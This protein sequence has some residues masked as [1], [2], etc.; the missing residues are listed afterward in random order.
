M[1]F[2]LYFEVFF[3]FVDNCCKSS[4]ALQ[5][6]CLLWA[7]TLPHICR[8]MLLLSL[9]IIFWVSSQ[10]MS[11]LGFFPVIQGS[12]RFFT[13]LIFWDIFPSREFPGFQNITFLCKIVIRTFATLFKNCL[14]ICRL[15]ITAQLGNIYNTV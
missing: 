12:R 6:A 2:V 14:L 4:C 10:Y 11:V 3:S 5:L 7:R 13:I 9:L 1:F 15:L 8:K